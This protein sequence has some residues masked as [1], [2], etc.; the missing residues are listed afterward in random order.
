MKRRIVLIGPPASGKG[1]QAELIKAHY[2]IQPAS[3]GAMLREELARGTKLGLE[4]DRITREGNLVPDALILEMVD[5]WLKAHHDAFV[6]DGFPRTVPQAEGFDR[7]LEGYDAAVDCVLFF[8]VPEQTIRDRVLNRV[9]CDTC[10]H[11]YRVGM[12]VASLGEECPACK[13][14]LVRRADDSLVALS[15]RMELY[16]ELT[17]PVVDYYREKSIVFDLTASD[18]PETVFAEISSILEEIE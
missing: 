4:A 12:Q 11:I 10:G 1:T 5:G 3:T 13:G 14:R 8:N 2:G 6:V 9:S 16:R 15:R 17:L 18:R 7:L